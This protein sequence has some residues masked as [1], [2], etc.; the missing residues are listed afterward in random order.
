MKTN[1][2]LLLGL[3]WVKMVDTLAVT[4]FGVSHEATKREALR[5][6]AS[7]YDPLGEAS[8]ITLLGKMVFREGCDRHLP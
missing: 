4:F 8:P 6:L 5:S 1:E 3:P 2:A 7:I